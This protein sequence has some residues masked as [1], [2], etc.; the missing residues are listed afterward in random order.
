LKV[1]KGAQTTVD[2]RVKNTGSRDGA[3]I[4]EIYAALPGGLGEPPKRLVGFSKVHL[5][6][7]ESKEVSVPIDSKYLSIFDEG[8]NGFKLVA[9]KYSFMVGGSSDKMPLKETV[10]LP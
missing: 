4:A 8:Q 6:A 5:K 7:G 3:E 2:F 9:G 1:K 10:S